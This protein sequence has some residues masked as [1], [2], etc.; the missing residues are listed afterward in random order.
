VPAA[1]FPFVPTPGLPF[2]DCDG[3]GAQSTRDLRAGYTTSNKPCRLVPVKI[4]VVWRSD[5]GIP[6]KYEEFHLLNYAG[7]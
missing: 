1:R 2:L 6:G 4:A 5:A 7:Y 3:D